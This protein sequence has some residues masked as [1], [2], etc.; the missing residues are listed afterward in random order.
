MGNEKINL[1]FFK[2]KQNEL[3][4]QMKLN[5]NALTEAHF[6]GQSDPH[7]LEEEPTVLHETKTANFHNSEIRQQARLRRDKNLWNSRLRVFDQNKST[8][9]HVLDETK[10]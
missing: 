8:R 1:P 4:R 5:L 3:R 6:E 7:F 9:A 2:S 10:L